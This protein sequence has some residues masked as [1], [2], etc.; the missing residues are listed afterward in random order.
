MMRATA[1]AAVMALVLSGC[2]LR[3]INDAFRPLPPT[4]TSTSSSGPTPLG[5]GP[6]S[7]VVTQLTMPPGSELAQSLDTY[8]ENWMVD[9]NRDSVESYLAPQLPVFR[10]FDGRPWC[11]TATTEFNGTKET[12]W[13]WGAAD[14]G[15]MIFVTGSTDSDH[16][17]VLVVTGATA[18]KNATGCTR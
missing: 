18:G 16:S 3:D 12:K 17:R 15:L 9:R 2:S 4:G 8:F 11:K 6:R 5:T 10:E 13:V 14:T 1:A 7:Q